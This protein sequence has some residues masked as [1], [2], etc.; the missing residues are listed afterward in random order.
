[1]G[2]VATTLTSYAIDLQVNKVTPIRRCPSHAPAKWRLSLD[3]SGRKKLPAYA[4]SFSLSP[5]RGAH[6][7]NKSMLNRLSL[8]RF[9]SDTHPLESLQAL[10]THFQFGRFFCPKKIVK[11]ATPRRCH[12]KGLMLTICNLLGSHNF[13][14]RSRRLS[15]S[16]NANRP[17]MQL[18]TPQHVRCRR[19]RA[20]E[21]VQQQRRRNKFLVGKNLACDRQSDSRMPGCC[22][23]R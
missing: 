15:A 11:D 22:G 13:S 6:R 14:L 19:N 20:D 17:F 16:R 7:T 1:V 8:P 5:A 2:R 10:W 4:A 12:V 18:Q 3:I 23:K 21:Q 9:K